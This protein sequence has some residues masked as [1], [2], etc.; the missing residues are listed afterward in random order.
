MHSARHSDAEIVDRLRSIEVGTIGPNGA[1]KNPR[2]CFSQI[3]AS[4]GA[5]GAGRSVG[6]GSGLCWPNCSSV[7]APGIIEPADEVIIGG[8]D[9]ARETNSDPAQSQATVYQMG[10]W[11]GGGW[12]ENRRRSH[13]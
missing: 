11:P 7:R 2:P 10:Q 3:A 6:A 9:A 5:T 1:K 12:R 13:A 8:P 4:T